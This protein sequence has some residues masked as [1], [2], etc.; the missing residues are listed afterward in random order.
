MKRI[1]TKE[2]KN[3][4]SHFIL[5][6]YDCNE[7]LLYFLNGEIINIIHNIITLNEGTVLSKNHHIFPNDA[8]TIIYL[9]SE[10][11]LSLHS[12]PENKYISIDL[13]TCGENIISFNIVTLLIKYFNSKKPIIQQIIRN[14]F[15]NIKMI[16]YNIGDYIT[17]NG[18]LYRGYILL[19][20]NIDNIFRVVLDNDE[21]IVF[22]RDNIEYNIQSKQYI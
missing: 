13:Y 16:D 9:L 15:N 5:D 4:G 1:I 20:Y 19:D 6:L 21:E 7:D 10:S 8:Y 12:F 2:E 17:N 18:I 11:H 14:N 3:Y 22:I